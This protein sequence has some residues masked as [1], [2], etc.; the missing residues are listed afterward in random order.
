[1]KA[2]Q[3]WRRTKRSKLEGAPADLTEGDEDLALLG[4]LEEG[5]VV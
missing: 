1:M 4:A 2:G 3:N 5:V